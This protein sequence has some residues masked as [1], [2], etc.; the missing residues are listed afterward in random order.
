MDLVIFDCDGTL[1]DSES[2][3]NLAMQY[4]LSDLGVH[5]EADDLLSKFRGIKM[6]TILSSLETELSIKLPKDFEVEFRSK[7]SILFEEQLKAN[8]GVENL[9]ELLRIPFCVASSAPRA[10]IEHALQVTGLEKYFSNNIFSSYDVGSWKP[11]PEIFLHAAKA[12]NTTPQ[13]CC[14]IEDSI[15]GLQAAQRASMNSVY[16]APHITERNLL[17]VEQIQHMSELVGKLN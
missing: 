12:M 9:L 6:A 1:V 4:Q 2:L 3:S 5:Y 11:E 8:D 13:D 10:K 7:V 15:V 14:V 17:G 16:Y